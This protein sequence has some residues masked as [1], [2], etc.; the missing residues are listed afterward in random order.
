M[1]ANAYGYEA[2]NLLSGLGQWLANS[3]PVEGNIDITTDENYFKKSIASFSEKEVNSVRVLKQLDNLRAKFGLKQELQIGKF[4]KLLNELG[5]ERRFDEAI[6]KEVAQS[7]P[8]LNS[9][10]SIMV[11][12]SSSLLESALLMPDDVFNGETT[13]TLGTAVGEMADA[14]LFLVSHVAVGKMP[15]GLSPM[16]MKR[17]IEA[18]NGNVQI[19]DP[20]VPAEYNGYHIPGSINVTSR[21]DKFIDFLKD[22]PLDKNLPTIFVCNSG[23]RAA[24]SAYQAMDYGFRKVYD[25]AGGTV[26]WVGSGSPTIMPGQTGEYN[27]PVIP[28]SPTIDPG[29][30]LVPIEDY[31]GGC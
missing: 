19:I 28:L 24:E 26:N 21:T 17:L 15:I 25:L 30:G 22:G 8:L 18:K 5:V 14:M 20:R 10:L 12:I 13:K 29:E 1:L 3:S 31:S 4:N 2:Y 16:G 27:E 6:I 23:A 7:S 11:N 9:V